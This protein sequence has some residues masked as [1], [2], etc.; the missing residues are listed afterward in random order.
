M[1][2]AMGKLTAIG[3]KTAKSGRHADGKGLYL[4]VK[5]TGARSWVLRIV[6]DGRRR[7]F[8]LGPADLVTLTEARDKAIEGRRIVRDGGDPGKVWKRAKVTTP[9][10][11][12][13]ARQFHDNNKAGWKNA[14]HS[15]QWLSTL[16]TYVFPTLG[17]MLP[18]E[19]D[20]PLIWSVLGPIWQDKSETAR[21]VR[22]RI[23]KVLDYAA[24]HGWRSTDAPM[25]ALNQ[26]TSRQVRKAGH[27]AAMPYGELPAFMVTLRDGEPSIGRLALMFTILTAARSGEV[28]GATW[29]EIDFDKAVWTVPG[30]RMKTGQAHRVPLS[31]PAVAIL[32]Q[33]QGLISGQPGE[34]IFPG[35]RGNPLSDATLAKA[36]RVAGGGNYTVHGTARSSFRD[37]VAEKMPTVP[38]DVAE[39]ALAHAIANKTEAAYRR[40]KYLDQRRGLMTAWADFLAGSSNVVRLAAA[41]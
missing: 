2:R 27:H 14:K 35:L 12:A 22:Q 34:P 23:G 7:D 10:F 11:E 31:D 6:V 21:R 28:R 25:R 29:D 18:E 37:W 20:A 36:M 9:T 13:V 3:V 41:N 15:A 16:E 32:A 17:D 5:E 24:A 4:L 1:E 26:I 19:I 8:G 33:M 38:S 40:T 30:E 39:A